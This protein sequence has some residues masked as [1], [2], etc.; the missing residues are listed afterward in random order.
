[1]RRSLTLTVIFLF[2]ITSSIRAAED[3]SGIQA[4]WKQF[5]ETWNR[6]DAHAFSL[7]FSPDADFTNWRG[8]HVSGRAVIEER[9]HPMF[10]G[11]IFKDSV[12]SG[13]VRMIRFLRPDIAI[14]DIDWEMT[15][16]RSADGSARPQ[17]KGLLDLVCQKQ[18]QD[19]RIVVLHDTDFTAASIIP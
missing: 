2:C 9:M 8:Q 16:A 10:S 7:I 12:C 3:E 14:V 1:M 13:K 15:G 18:G 11:P 19:W 17:R 6:H 4:L 5:L